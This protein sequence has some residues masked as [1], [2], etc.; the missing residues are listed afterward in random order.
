MVER[1]I[2]LNMIFQYTQYFQLLV[3]VVNKS[4]KRYSSTKEMCKNGL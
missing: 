3:F 2:S 1:L 4:S